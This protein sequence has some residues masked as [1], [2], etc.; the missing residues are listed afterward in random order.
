MGGFAGLSATWH[1]ACLSGMKK[2]VDAMRIGQYLAA[3]HSNQQVKSIEV[4]SNNLANA[5]TPGF[6]K[7]AVYFRDML[8]QSTYTKMDPGNIRPTGNPLDIAIRGD[9][10]LRVQTDQGVMFTRVG[11]L[12]VNANKQ[13]V[14][15]D[16]WPVLGKNGVITLEG[17]TLRIEPDGQIFDDGSMLD[18][19]D[20]VR[21]SPESRP[22]KVHNGY[23]TTTRGAAD[24][25]P[26]EGV[27]IEQG[28]LEES[29]I[30][31]VE[32]MA[33]MID[34]FRRYESCQKV[35]RTFDELQSQLIRTSSGL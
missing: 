6:K 11:S 19:L 9:G 20:I 31:T 8:K 4:V 24:I 12:S 3:L 17:G 2:G 13:L 34:I 15:H 16:G 32:E 35:L 23:F 5:S 25:I 1:L 21:I 29:N 10:F 33:R 27:S 30:N 26:A 18:T 14:T 28:A 7:D 22:E